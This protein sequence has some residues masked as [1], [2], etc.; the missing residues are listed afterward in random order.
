LATK[1]AT[2][3]DAE[4]DYLE[5]K[6]Q[7]LKQYIDDRPLTTLTDRVGYR[8]DKNGVQIPYIIATIEAQRK[9]LTAARKEYA[10]LVSFIN[11]KREQEE[12][13]QI[14]ARGGKELNYNQKRFARQKGL[15]SDE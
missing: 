5:E 8:T 10:E 6:L 13:K 12:K 14:Q 11:D 7:E 4:L 2:Y 9:D 15:A 3:I 1:K